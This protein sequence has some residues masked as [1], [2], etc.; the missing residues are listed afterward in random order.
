MV[1]F[2]GFIIP[3][4]IEVL[5]SCFKTFFFKDYYSR[6]LT[7]KLACRNWCS[8]SCIFLVSTLLR[9]DGSAKRFL[10]SHRKRSLMIFNNC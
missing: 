6:F 1:V 5:K 2:F 4:F 8:Y 10:F 9:K 7:Q 3:Y